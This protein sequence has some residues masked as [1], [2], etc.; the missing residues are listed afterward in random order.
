MKKVDEFLNMKKPVKPVSPDYKDYRDK[1]KPENFEKSPYV[2]AL[3]KYGKELEQYEKDVE[4]YE[5]IKFIKFI[6]V[7]NF[8]LCLEK[9]KVIKK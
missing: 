3:N 4:L 5:Q 1:E 8:R 2:L 7:A 6:K 9:Y